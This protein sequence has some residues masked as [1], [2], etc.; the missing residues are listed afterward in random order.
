MKN[1]AIISCMRRRICGGTTQNKT[2]LS[3][4]IIVARQLW[5]N[6]HYYGSSLSKVSIKATLTRIE[7]ATTHTKA[8]PES[9]TQ[10]ISYI[11][12]FASEF[13]CYKT[14]LKLRQVLQKFYSTAVY[15]SIIIQRKDKNTVTNEN[16]M[17][18]T[19]SCRISV[20]VGWG[21]IPLNRPTQR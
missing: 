4:L 3:A 2:D 9:T 1:I 20:S 21:T 5:S 13:N 6:L 14:N 17:Y 12:E 15:Q 19:S 16:M 7:Q 18:E 8:S 11:T 10:S